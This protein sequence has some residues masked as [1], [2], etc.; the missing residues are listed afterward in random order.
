MDPTPS[1]HLCVINIYPCVINNLSDINNYEMIFLEN[2]NEIENS[3]R[4]NG[5][6]TSCM[7]DFI[8]KTYN[9]IHRYTYHDNDV[10]IDYFMF[11]SRY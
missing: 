5:I 9:N 1:H 6:E 3:N 7:N 8:F 4:I 10:I 2:I 11:W